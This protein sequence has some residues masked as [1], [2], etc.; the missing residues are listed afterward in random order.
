MKYD[1]KNTM[2]DRL[3]LIRPYGKQIEVYL[4]GHESCAATYAN[5]NYNTGI[6]VNAI[7]DERLIEEKED[8]KTILC[9]KAKKKI[10]AHEEILLDY[11][12]KFYFKHSDGQRNVISSNETEM[13][14][15]QEMAMKLSNE[16]NSGLFLTLYCRIC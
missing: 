5:S 9:L 1:E 8:Y 7:F 3:I 6:E 10:S 16:I 14:V 12:N 13:R 4:D 2:P 15:E 11:G